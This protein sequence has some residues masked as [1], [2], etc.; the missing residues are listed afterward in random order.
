MDNLNSDG[1][2]K[3]M[4]HL[5]ARTIPVSQIELA[6]DT[7][8]KPWGTEEEDRQLL[9]SIR[10]FGVL[11]PILVMPIAP[12]RFLIIDGQRRFKF[13]K[14]LGYTSLVCT[15]HRKIDRVELL[16]LRWDL[17]ATFKPLTQAEQARERRRIRELGF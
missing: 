3:H 15:I 1:R 13:A 14:Q 6:P 9:E 5:D 4:K 10:H 8:R 11:S 12:K 2:V 17:E 7:P 16:K